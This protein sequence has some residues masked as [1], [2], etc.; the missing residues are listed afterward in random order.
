[1]KVAIMK[2]LLPSGIENRR[3]KIRGT[4]LGV[5]ISTAG[6]AAADP[7]PG[8]VFKEFAWKRE[9]SQLVFGPGATHP[10]APK[11]PRPARVPIVLDLDGA[12]KAEVIVE[13]WSGHEGT[14]EKSINFN[15]GAWLRLPLP[16]NT[17]T[18][19]E[20]YFAMLNR[21]A[22]EVPLGHLQQGENF[23]SFTCGPQIAH[24]FD[25][26]A[27]SVHGVTVRVYYSPSQPHACARIVAPAAGATLGDNPEFAVAILSPGAGVARV[28]YLVEYEG[29]P[30]GGDGVF[31][32]WHCAYQHTK[33]VR[34]AATATAA[35]WRATWDTRWIAD[36]RQPMRLLARVTDVNGVVAM[37]PIVD[38]LTF[39]RARSVGF[40]PASGVKQYF[41]SQYG[42]KSTCVINW[43]ERLPKATA[44]HLIVATHGPQ[45][46]PGEFGL[47]GRRLGTVAAQPRGQGSKVYHEVDVPLEV[48]RTGDNEF[49]LLSETKGHALEGSWPGPSLFLEFK[50]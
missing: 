2:H 35:P 24:N 40:Y 42:R 9:R 21:P 27:F 32:A 12:T 16:R 46:A 4:L 39:W 10:E 3:S 34:P 25:Y 44:A 7:A 6:P 33:L 31:R 41:N 43:L 20:C 47:N 11:N 19:P 45:E 50:P 23:I 49:Y 48:L 17:P 15:G 8:D 28:E 1:M 38:G 29:F 5:L 13:H 26:P 18:A 36:Q 30:W 22:V 37:T 14:S